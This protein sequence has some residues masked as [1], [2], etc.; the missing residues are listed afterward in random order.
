LDR[1]QSLEEGISLPGKLSGVKAG[2]KLF[3][4]Q[5]EHVT[6]PSN[7]VITIVI[8]DGKVVMKRKSDSAERLKSRELKS[9]I[10]EQHLSVEKEVTEKVEGLIKKKGRPFSVLVVEP[11]HM[12]LNVTKR[13]LTK[14]GFFVVTANEA[15]KAIE[16]MHTRL[17]N[18][19]ISSVEL[20]GMDGLAF[21][22]YVRESAF[23]E[24]PFV[25]FS[26]KISEELFEKGMEVGVNYMLEKSVSPKGLTD[27]VKSIAMQ[28]EFAKGLKCSMEGKL[29]EMNT[30]AL[31]EKVVE[32]RETGI[33][34]IINEAV[35][36][37]IH[38]KD[39]NIIDAFTVPERGKE[40]FFSLMSVETEGLYHFIPTENETEITITE[41]TEHLIKEINKNTALN[42]S[43]NESLS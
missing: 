26:G 31:V 41:D 38:F 35:E 16:L 1:D 36:G 19:I 8:F 23:K 13:N 9:L 11:S 2:K 37:H 28:H 5:T 33:L 15:C 32:N 17:Y 10:Y 24:T 30:R 27:E 6:S 29:I 39:G 7:H 18:L 40:A 3:Q 14:A 4:I 21:C 34:S 20:K 22:K 42:S 43:Q 12:L 25:L